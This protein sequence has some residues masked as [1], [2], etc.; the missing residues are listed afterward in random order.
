M[1]SKRRAKRKP[2]HCGA[3]RKDPARF[4]RQDAPH[5]APGADLPERVAHPL[6]RYGRRIGLARFVRGLR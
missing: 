2:P 5:V 4:A 6:P 3:W 1:T